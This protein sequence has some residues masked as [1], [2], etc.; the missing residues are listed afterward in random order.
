MRN[1]FLVFVVLVSSCSLLCGLPNQKSVDHP[2]STNSNHQALQPAPTND[3]A[4]TLNPT[5]LG[6]DA[7]KDKDDGGGHQDKHEQ[8]RKVSI[9]S[10]PEVRVNQ[11][12]DLLDNRMLDCTIILTIVGVLGTVIALYTLCLIKREVGAA[13]EA[14]A[15]SAKLADAAE[16]T[17]G[18]VLA[19]ATAADVNS[20]SIKLSER[21][22]IQ[23]GPDMSGF[24]LENL[25]NRVA[26]FNWYM[27]N[28]GRTPA[29][30]VE[31]A[32][33]YRLIQSLKDIPEEPEWDGDLEKIPL[34]EMHLIPNERYWSYQVL[35]PSS[36]LTPDE[37]TAIGR[38]ERF[39]VAYGYVNY[40]DVFGD[41]HE[42][43]FCYSYYV[44]QGG[45]VTYAK[46]Q[47]RPYLQAP[48]AYKKTT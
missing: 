33:R 32:A 17:A 47:W 14:L 26:V 6:G 36:I 10:V 8:E 19:A 18:G 3:K 35:E 46:A 45:M 31:I 28:T 9:I 22:W 2:E 13:V 39:L 25:D 30:L 38:N 37:L 29:K 21:A 20:N 42:T 4:N 12:R 48:A 41:P 11:V 1:Y 5:N 15:H 27:S 40:L 24:K 43:W 7:A 44:P 34:Y 23:A 16:K